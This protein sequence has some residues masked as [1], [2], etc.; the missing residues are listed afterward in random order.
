MKTS[1]L[2]FGLLLILVTA[3][4]FA[5][6]YKCEGPWV[7]DHSV[8]HKATATVTTDRDGKPHAVKFVVNGDAAFVGTTQQIEG[9]YSFHVKSAESPQDFQM[10]GQIHF[11]MTDHPSRV[12]G[13]ILE[14]KEFDLTS[15]MFCEL[16]K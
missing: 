3:S 15:T 12:G 14:T 8:I 13:L 16:A 6:T 9:G 11:L 7:G 1:A 10:S 2:I 4:A 5:D